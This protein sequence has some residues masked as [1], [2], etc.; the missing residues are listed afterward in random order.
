MTTMNCHFASIFRLNFVLRGDWIRLEVKGEVLFSSLFINN[1][2][3]SE[4][5]QR[6]VASEQ[7]CQ[8]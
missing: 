4:M 1:G 5:K 2:D 8:F 7:H 6:W 3:G